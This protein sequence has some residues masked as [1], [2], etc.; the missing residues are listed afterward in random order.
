MVTPIVLDSEGNI[1]AQW[2]KEAVSAS[3]AAKVQ[4]AVYVASADGKMMDQ[5]LVTIKLTIDDQT[6]SSSGCSPTI[7]AG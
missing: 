5:V 6:Y 1:A 2:L 7:S 4:T 3:E